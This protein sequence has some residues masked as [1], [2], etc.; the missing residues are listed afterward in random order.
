LIDYVNLQHADGAVEELDD[1]A[2]IYT[3][4]QLEHSSPDEEDEEEPAE[5]SDTDESVEDSDKEEEED[6]V[7]VQH[8]ESDED[9]TVKDVFDTL[10]EEQKNVVYYMIGQALEDAEAEHSDIN[11]D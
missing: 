8:A 1:E 4:L 5:E 9:K 3:G 10:S 2:I 7:T 6:A 11:E